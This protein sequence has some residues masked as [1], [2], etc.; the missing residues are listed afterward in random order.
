MCGHIVDHHHKIKSVVVGAPILLECMRLCQSQPT[1]TS[2]VSSFRA[3]TSYHYLEVFA[4]RSGN[5]EKEH[6][7]FSGGSKLPFAGNFQSF[8]AYWHV[9]L[10]ATTSIFIVLAL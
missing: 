1:E 6:T 9:S 7:P 5:A 4:G 2:S 10:I 3:C 8:L